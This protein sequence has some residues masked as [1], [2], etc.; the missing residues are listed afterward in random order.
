VRQ[1]YCVRTLLSSFAQSQLRVPAR[2]PRSIFMLQLCH[3]SRRILNRNEK[4]APSWARLTEMRPCF[5]CDTAT[6]VPHVSVLCRTCCKVGV[7]AVP[8]QSLSCSL[9]RCRCIQ[10]WC[11][12]RSKV[13]RWQTLSLGAR[14][15]DRLKVRCEAAF[16]IPTYSAEL[17]PETPRR[18]A[19]PVTT[20]SSTIALIFVV[21]TCFHYYDQASERSPSRSLLW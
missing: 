1:R 16:T 6:S 10:I 11:T 21:R 3:S 9:S 13:K 20:H 19:E 7:C 14:K 8:L 15:A 12:D 18:C 17:L 5:E 2:L 4:H